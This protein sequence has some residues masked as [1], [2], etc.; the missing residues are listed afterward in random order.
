M[1]VIVNAEPRELP[2]QSSLQQLVAEMGV[3]ERKG[4]ALALNET[5]VPATQWEATALEEGDR[6]V[7]I[8]ASQGG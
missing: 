7:V 4:I 8:Q 3:A 2:A 6:V 1:K 5:V